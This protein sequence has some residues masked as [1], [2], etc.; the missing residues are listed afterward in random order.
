MRGR[1]SSR[2][3]SVRNLESSR[4]WGVLL[5]LAAVYIVAGKLGLRLAFVNAS[6]TAVW[7]PTGIALAAC[8]ILGRSVWPVIFFGAFVVNVTTAGGVLT[9]LGIATGNT[10]EAV[11]G[12]LLVDR[13]ATGRRSLEHPGGIF[14]F[15]L[16]A[17]GLSTMV[18]ATIGVLTLL[19]GGLA[20]LPNVGQVWLTWWLGDAGGAMVVA[21]VLLLWSANLRVRLHPRVLIEIAALLVTAVLVGQVAFGGVLPL[22]GWRLPLDFLSMPLC[23]WAAFRFG[24]RMSSVVVAVVYSLAVRGTLMGIGP[25]ARPSPNESLLLLQA[26]AAVIGVTTLTLAAIVR[27]RRLSETQLRQLSASD[28]LTGLTNYRY[29]V[30]ALE[31]EIQRSQRSERP[32]SVVFFDLD[33]LKKINDRHGHLVGSRALWRVAEVLRRTVRAIDT[34]ARY[35]GD[36]FALV[37]PDADEAAAQRVA[38]RVSEMLARDPEPPRVS[39][40]AGVALFPRDGSGVSELLN[41]ADRAQYAVKAR[42]SGGDGRAPRTSLA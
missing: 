14:R 21:P 17:A 38:S 16:L 13:F 23:I 9:S 26:F 29:L 24:R 42:G 37:L 39:I 18:S 27:E 34:A 8:L 2:P 1:M 36:E 11:V 41:A 19:L 15:A 4:R 6:A 7:P 28:P 22:R 3:L 35:G 20:S 31:R 5:G 12:S 10:L 30:E 32:F 40:S 25:F 33:G